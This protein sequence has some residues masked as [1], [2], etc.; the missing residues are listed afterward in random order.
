MRTH[1]FDAFPVVRGG[2]LAGI[3]TK[4]DFMMMFG[5]GTHLSRRDYWNLFASNFEGVMR[6][7]VIT[8][9]PDDTL[10]A[11]AECMIQFSIRSTPVADGSKL[12]GIVSRNDLI[13][14]LIPSRK[15][16]GSRCHR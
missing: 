11:A 5:L 2:S 13:E 1:D 16:A 7:G 3:V 9:R 4:L 10:K 8:V 15:G 6:T 12:E 14:H